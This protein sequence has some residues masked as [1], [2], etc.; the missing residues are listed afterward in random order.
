MGALSFEIDS[1][2]RKAETPP[3]FFYTSQAFFELQKEK[4]FARSWQLIADIEKVQLPGQ[5]FP[6]TF[7]EGLLD[8]PMVITRDSDDHLHVLSNVCTHR[9][10]L[11]CETPGYERF[12]RC[13]YHGRRFGLDGKFQH[14]PEFE[15]VEDFPT[16]KDHL[17]EIPFEV[18]EPWIFAS[19]NPLTSWSDS[20]SFLKNR[21]GWMPL[22]DFRFEPSRAQDFVVRANW[23]LYCDNYLEGFHIPFV[24]ASLNALLDYENYDVELHKFGNLQIGV[25]KTGEDCFE[26]PKESQDYGKN[27]AAYYFWVFPNLM[28]NFYPWGCSVNIVRPLEVNRTKVSFLPYVWKPE[29]F[30]KGAGADLTRVEREDEAVVE[31]THRGLQSRLY[32]RGRY[33]P[34]REK[35][36]HHFHKLL[37]NILSDHT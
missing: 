35:G 30:D 3:G 26:L 20:F 19:V 15:N 6:F 33:S 23:A 17:S 7:L 31:C 37:T 8:E 1:D 36:V 4:V 28:F 10:N 5:V 14:M 34:E 18:F 27:I 24:H 12:L 29:L 25:S 2:I 22:Q 11:V 21:I 13:R 32:N 9:G 16:T